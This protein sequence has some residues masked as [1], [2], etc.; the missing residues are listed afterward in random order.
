MD[1]TDSRI[2]R[3]AEQFNAELDRC[4]KLI[5]EDDRSVRAAIAFVQASLTLT[6]K[7]LREEGEGAPTHCKVC[8]SLF[9]DADG[10]PVCGPRCAE[11]L[12]K[13]P[14]DAASGGEACDKCGKPEDDFWHCREHDHACDQP[15]G[16][17]RFEPPKPPEARA[18]DEHNPR[19]PWANPEG[20]DWRDQALTCGHTM[21]TWVFIDEESG[22]GV[23]GECATRKYHPAFAPPQRASGANE[24]G[25]QSSIFTVDGFRYDCVQGPK[26]EGRCLFMQAKP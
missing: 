9:T 6:V 7:A 1:S 19:K 21:R 15:K 22:H 13:P 20:D 5:D 14:T 26:H 23:C 11:Q 12:A 16:F 10:G 24:H 4:R 17:H 18:V 25:C 3:F 8:G 2:L